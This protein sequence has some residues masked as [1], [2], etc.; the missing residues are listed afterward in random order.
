MWGTDHVELFVQSI[1]CAGV[2]FGGRGERR[3]EGE[4]GG[5]GDRKG[6]ALQPFATFLPAI[7]WGGDACANYQREATTARGD[8]SDHPKGREATLCN[9]SNFRVA[10]ARAS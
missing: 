2:F 3:G 4:E 10:G 9:K 6:I 8:H 1:D 7:Q 5:G